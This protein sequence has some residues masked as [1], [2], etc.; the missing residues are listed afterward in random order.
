MSNPTKALVQTAPAA[1]ETVEAFVDRKGRQ[2]AAL[3]PNF[4]LRCWL[5]SLGLLRSV[6]RRTAQMA[7]ARPQSSV[8]DL[9]CGTGGV[10]QNLLRLF[11]RVVG[12]D[13]SAEMLAVAR[14]RCPG[15]EFICGEAGSALPGGPFDAAV[16]ALG[17]HEM[18]AHLRET[19][20][21]RATQAVRRGGRLVLSDYAWPRT[22]PMRRIVRRVAPVLIEPDIVDFLDWPLD[23][24]MDRLGFQLVEDARM[25]F[26]I[27]RLSAWTRGP[28]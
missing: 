20:L 5:Y 18:P 3:A 27:L 2:F 13:L 10:T 22:R 1:D 19:L 7:M 4:E 21:E 9:C 28:R 12:V 6:R 14:R 23:A 26:G 24:V 11:P 15:A 25:Y 17:L 8:L 16:L